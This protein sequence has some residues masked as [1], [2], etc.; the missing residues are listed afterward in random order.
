MSWLD[1]TGFFFQ[2]F[3]SRFYHADITKRRLEFQSLLEILND[4]LIKCFFFFNLN[5]FIYGIIL[6]FSNILLNN[7]SWSDW[8][9]EPQKHSQVY[10]SGK[11]GY[12]Y[13]STSAIISLCVLFFFEKASGDRNKTGRESVFITNVKIDLLL[14]ACKTLGAIKFQE[15]WVVRVYVYH[16]LITSFINWEFDHYFLK[17]WA[18]H[19]L[20]PFPAVHYQLESNFENRKSYEFYL[21]TYW[22]TRHPPHSWSL[23]FSSMVRPQTTNHNHIYFDFVMTVNAKDVA[24]WVTSN[25][26]QICSSFVLQV[27][28]SVVYCMFHLTTL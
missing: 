1:Q 6:D 5:T 2:F 13:V 9:M 22:L 23:L 11:D 10:I 26:I 15:I 28:F 7:H 25:S 21:A 3:F 20:S 12:Y 16:T 24:W 8:F 14:F 19:A 18:N 17:L 4:F 27:M